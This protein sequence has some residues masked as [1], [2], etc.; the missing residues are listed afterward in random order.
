MTQATY[1]HDPLNEELYKNASTFLADINN[2][3][4]I[5][6]TYKENLAKLDNFVMLRFDNDSM[7]Q[8]VASEW[9]GFYKPG[10][11]VDIEDLKDSAIYQEVSQHCVLSSKIRSDVC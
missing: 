5:N 11:S 10:Q 3:K 7:V 9:F 1:W 8:P 4:N 6:E 2:E